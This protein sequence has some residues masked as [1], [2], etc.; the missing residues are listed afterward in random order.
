MIRKGQQKKKDEGKKGK[1][2]EKVDP[3]KA[4][5]AGYGPAKKHHAPNT[6]PIKEFTGKSQ[7]NINVND[8]GSVAGSKKQRR[9]EARKLQAERNEERAK[10]AAQRGGPGISYGR[11]IEDISPRALKAS[12][13][14]DLPSQSDRSLA[15]TVKV[16]LP[17]KGDLV[18]KKV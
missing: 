9:Q 18:L 11:T 15:S 4:K 6:D 10:R 14:G 5:R 3:R 13:Y 12:S 17:L 16:K 1:K 8:Y 2:K 7:V